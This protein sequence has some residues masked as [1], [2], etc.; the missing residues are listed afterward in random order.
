MIHGKIG[1]RHILM[2]NADN[3]AKHLDDIDF[4]TWE[5]RH[6]AVKEDLV[7]WYRQIWQAC[8]DDPFNER[9][10]GQ[11][12]AISVALWYLLDPKEYKALKHGK[13]YIDQSELNAEQKRLFISLN[14]FNGSPYCDHDSWD[15]VL[16]SYLLRAKP[17]YQAL[18]K[19]YPKL[20]EDVAF[21]IAVKEYSEAKNG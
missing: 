17:M 20:A 11:L 3:I 9:L 1:K 5:E 12:A 4:R 21:N 2:S 13:R 15:T 18:V 8:M 14:A 6:E 19:K 16:T 10:S 7:E